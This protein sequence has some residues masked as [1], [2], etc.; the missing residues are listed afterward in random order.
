MDKFAIRTNTFW[1][2]NLKAK[3]HPAGKWISLGESTAK[4]KHSHFKKKWGKKEEIWGE[5]EQVTDGVVG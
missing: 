4:V 2:N 5:E 1:C 3:A